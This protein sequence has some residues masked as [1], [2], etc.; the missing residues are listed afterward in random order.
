LAFAISTPTRRERTRVRR[1][2]PSP[3]N[4]ERC[5]ALALNIAAWVVIWTVGSRLLGR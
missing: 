4:L 2:Q 1:L 3:I 5:L